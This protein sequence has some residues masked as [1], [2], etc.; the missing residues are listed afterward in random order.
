MKKQ[1]RPAPLL[2]AAILALSLLAECADKKG[3]QDDDPVVASYGETEIRR[4]LV[5]YEKQNQ[6]ALSGGKAVSDQEAVDQL[7]ENLAMLDEAEHLGLSV[8]QEEVDEAFAAQQQAGMVEA[9]NRNF[10]AVVR[11]AHP[12]LFEASRSKA[13]NERFQADMQAWIEQKP[14]AEAAP[15][16]DVFLH[17]RDPHAVA[18]LITRF[19]NERQASQKARTNP[20]GAFAVPRRG[21]PV[22][23]QGVG[24][25]DDF[26]AG[27]NI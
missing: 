17:G 1:I 25:K 15:L 9:A 24:S 27:W 22:V 2:A 23:P 8:S 14:Y 16:M 18:E 11:Q 26:D 5:D 4:S 19:K 7:L 6:Q 10:V 12:D 21:A 20:D 13:D 3:V